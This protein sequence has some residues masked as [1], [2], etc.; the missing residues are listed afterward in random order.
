M[1]IESSLTYRSG[2]C[3]GL[4]VL[5]AKRA[6]DSDPGA[7]SY[8]FNYPSTIGDTSEVTNKNNDYS[9]DNIDNIHCWCRGY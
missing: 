9:R 7:H 6:L 1:V 2:P 4:W 3:P 5:R 8:K